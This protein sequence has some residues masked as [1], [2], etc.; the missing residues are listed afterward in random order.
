LSDGGER[1]GF[2]SCGSGEKG[3]ESWLAGVRVKESGGVGVFGNFHERVFLADTIRSGEGVGGV[4]SPI[5]IDD[6][7]VALGSWGK[8]EEEGPEIFFL[9]GKGMGGWI[10]AVEGAGDADRFF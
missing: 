5:A 8:R 7:F 4:E 2:P 10:P 3:E 9:A 1:G 6:Q